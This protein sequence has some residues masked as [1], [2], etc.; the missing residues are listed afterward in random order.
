MATNDG[1]SCKMMTV[2]EIIVTA[3][4]DGRLL[5]GLSEEH[6]REILTED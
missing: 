6:R 5:Q 4:N 1:R 3:V 2:W